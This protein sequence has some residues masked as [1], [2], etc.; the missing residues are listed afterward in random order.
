MQRCFI[1]SFLSFLFL[2]FCL[3]GAA[4][5]SRLLWYKGKKLSDTS[6]QMASGQR[7][8]YSPTRGTVRVTGNNAGGMAATIAGR[9]KARE[10]FKKQVIKVITQGPGGSKIIDLAS[11]AEAA[12]DAVDK[13]MEEKTAGVHEI[14]IEGRMIP[15]SVND[16]F[17]AVVNYVVDL[18]NAEKVKPEPPPATSFDY[19]FPCDKD[20]QDKYAEDTTAYRVRFYSDHGNMISKAL[21]VIRYFEIAR[22]K[23]TSFNPDDAARMVPKMEEDIEYMMNDMA[24]KVMRAWEMYKNNAPQLPLLIE[25]VMNTQRQFD[26]LAMNV[27]EGYPDLNEIGQQMLEG[28]SKYYDEALKKR[29]YPVLLNISWYVGMLR[30]AT[31]LFGEMDFPQKL[32]K[33]LEGNR[34]EMIVDTK[35]EL[36]KDGQTIHAKMKGSNFYRAVPDKECKLRWHLYEPSDRMMQF[37]LE[38][39]EMNMGVPASYTGTKHWET[40]PADIQ[41]GFCEK[42]ERDTLLMQNFHAKGAESWIVQGQTIPGGFITGVLMNCFMDEKRMREMAADKQLQEKLQKE[43]MAEYQKAIAGNEQLMAKDPATMTKE[44]REKLQKVVAAT[45]NIQAKLTTAAAAYNV[46]FKE[47]LQNNLKTVFEKEIDGR[48]LFPRNTAIQLAK[49]KIQLIHVEGSD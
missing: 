29:D 25:M 42:P 41:L 35:A 11:Q 4:Q 39:A 17:Y 20:R 33:F 44:E 36:G 38:K 30:Q 27:P 43:M 26:L 12:I 28:I 23:G 3:E 5:T 22:I 1:H 40:P 15:D 46:L 24:L 47:S 9:L 49:F 2:A 31:L 21:K 45:Q 14:I 48:A 10:Q 37:N 7:V 16:F 19:C 34:F 13:K 18:K 6:L 8:I 32:S